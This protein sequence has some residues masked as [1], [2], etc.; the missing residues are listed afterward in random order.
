[1]ADYLFPCDNCGRDSERSETRLKCEK[2]DS[3]YC[4][5]LCATKHQEMHLKYCARVPKEAEL[6]QLKSQSGLFYIDEL[7]MALPG[8]F[9]EPPPWLIV[10]SK[11]PRFFEMNKIEDDIS[12]KKCFYTVRQSIFIN[13]ISVRLPNNLYEEFIQMSKM[14][15]KGIKT[16]NAEILKQT[17]DTGARGKKR[18]DE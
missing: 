8:P 4:C 16:G 2:C 3:R 15:V 14:F 17:P 6:A 11:L 13:V 10:A 1:M 12:K 7:M 5:D 9:S 18:R